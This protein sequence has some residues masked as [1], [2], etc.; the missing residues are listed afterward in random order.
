[1]SFQDFLSKKVWFVGFN[2][3]VFGILFITGRLDGSLVSFISLALVLVIVNT[4]AWI[5]ARCYKEWC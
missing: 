1:M 3:A 4:L 2:I 5:S